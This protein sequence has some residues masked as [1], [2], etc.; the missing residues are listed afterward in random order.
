MINAIFKRMYDED[1]N[2]LCCTIQGHALNGE[3]GNDVVCAG[4]SALAI[5]AVNSLEFLALT[6]PI[7]KINDEVG[8]LY[9]EPVKGQTNEHDACAQIL[10]ESL[11]LGLMTIEEDYGKYI[12]VENV[13][14][15]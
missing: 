7:V 13:Y 3:Y 10:L 14:N 9:I 8:Y 12:K 11:Y 15:V 2:I 5:N 4:V 6:K 1:M